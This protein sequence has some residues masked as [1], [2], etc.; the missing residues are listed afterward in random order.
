[1]ATTPT[2]YGR[3]I[4]RVGA[5]A[6][7][8]GIGAA[9]ANSPGLAWAQDGDGSGSTSSA[10]GETGTTSTT[11][12]TTGTTGTITGTGTTSDPQLKDAEKT[13]D[14]KPGDDEEQDEKKKDD[15]KQE[16]PAETDSHSKP[17]TE[18]TTPPPDSS[19]KRSNRE[20]QQPT[21]EVV[22]QPTT[23]QTWTPPDTKHSNEVEEPQN[24]AVTTVPDTQTQR[25][26]TTF[27]TID[28]EP[29][30]TS[31]QLAAPAPTPATTGLGGFVGTILSALGFGSQAAAGPQAPPQ[32]PLLWAVLGWVRREI[33]NVFAAFAPPAAA[34]PAATLMADE[35]SVAVTESP[36]ATPEQLAAERIA[37]QTAN[38]LPVAIMKLILKQQF[39]AA[40][41]NLYG[42][43]GVDAANLA[44]VDKAVNEYAMA[45]AFQQQLLDSMNPTV[46]T[47][48]APPHIWFGQDVAGGR[49]LYDN[50]DTIYR[51]MGVNGASEYVIR[52]QFHNW[53]DPAS[54]PA[55]VTFS[56]LEGLAGTTS[57][58][59]TVDD[60]FVVDD[61]GNFVITV[62][63][64]ATGGPNHLQL[65]AGST[66]IAARDTLG[67]WNDEIPMSLSIERVGGP[68]NSLFA[69][70]GG[71][72]FLGNIVASNPLLT[73]LVSLVPPL[74]YMPPLLRGVFSAAILIV[75]G[76]GEQAKYMA[77]ATKDPATGTPRAVNTVSQ[78]AS[79][80][81][82]LA[83]QLQSNGHFQLE[84]DQALVLTIDPGTAK[85]FVVPVYDI[86]T[87]TDN[88][89]DLPTSLNNEQAIENV[90]ENG[91]PTGTYTVII[92][93]TDPLARNWISTGGLNQGTL[94]I[95]FQDLDPESEDLPRIIDQR[96]MTHDELRDF[97][98]AG[99][100]ITAQQRAELLE[101]RKAGYNNRWAPFPQP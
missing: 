97:L 87:I 11:G 71:F 73:T 23:P 61:D 4:G 75:R 83:N 31:Q 79:N 19:T 69:Q 40:A 98:P 9:I 88:Y 1:M 58:V 5:L 68:P 42:P 15:E 13:D 34:T 16:P 25:A 33:G 65:T 84:D 90:D 27:T 66:I 44:A 76:A 77:L 17:T 37:T 64:S 67:N 74:P 49:I 62:S 12:T 22:N 47:Q 59:L 35:V 53:P 29:Q 78:P 41:N 63:R 50:P 94:A 81:E 91:N 70:L 54:R 60:N 72:A 80:A 36:L 55:N 8:L 45:A 6:V 3:F 56:V 26:A 10:A 52:G 2:G 20:E 46:V 32:P 51:F 57:T 48:V 85:Y 93:P 101:L 14:E 82:F 18:P 95:R 24:L 43:G 7:A 96:V 100:F 28:P 38:S 99:D 39:L 89:W 30:Q 21:A 86:W 92:S